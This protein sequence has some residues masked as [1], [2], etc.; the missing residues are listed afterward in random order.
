MDAKPLLDQIVACIDDKDS[1]VR[2]EALAALAAIG[3]DARDKGLTAVIESLRSIDGPVVTQATDT[4]TKLGQPTK[5]QLATLRKCLKDTIGPI[6]QYGLTSVGGLKLQAAD[7]ADDVREFLKNEGSVELRRRAVGVLLAIDPVSDATRDALGQSLSDTDPQVAKLCIDALAKTTFDNKLVGLLIKAL[8]HEDA[9]VR[10]KA[11]TV[12]SAGPL[13]SVHVPLME[14][15]LKGK[16]RVQQKLILGLLKS[17]KMKAAPTIPLLIDILK[18][19]TALELRRPTLDA[20]KT[21]GIEA[22]QAGAVL[23]EVQK[24][25]PPLVQIEIAEFLTQI[26]APEADKAMPVVVAKLLLPPDA[27]GEATQW[28]EQAILM[29]NRLESN[30]VPHLVK[31]LASF[32]GQGLPRADARL[33]VIKMLGEIGGKKK[34]PQNLAILQALVDVQRT[35]NELPAIKEAAKAAFAQVSAAP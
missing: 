11:Q 4:L 23:V 19:G 6:K 33:T 15:I 31:G 18:D 21:M 17:M 12:L 2:K 22:R 35:P 8:D 13:S 16:N 25:E 1:R 26:A 7:A 27:Q 9:Q 3:P 29:L 14:P 28:K 24:G 30:A 5:S 20:L 32:S 10:Q 34:T